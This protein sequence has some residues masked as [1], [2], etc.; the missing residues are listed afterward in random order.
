MNSKGPPSR[1]RSERVSA[2]K[3]DAF[4]RNSAICVG[5]WE[6]A[7]R[8]ATCCFLVAFYTSPPLPSPPVTS[9]IFSHNLFLLPRPPLL[10]GRVLHPLPSLSTPPSP[11]LPCCL[12]NPPRVA[13]PR[14]FPSGSLCVCVCMRHHITKC[15]TQKQ[16][17]TQGLFPDSRHCFIVSGTPFV[18][19]F[20]FRTTPAQAALCRRLCTGASVRC[21][22]P[23]APNTLPCRLPTLGVAKIVDPC[24]T[25][26]Q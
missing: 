10:G 18:A 23:P 11:A 9:P 13:L 4:V 6:A 16:E 19:P 7:G 22:R 1:A 5:E 26:T 12:S 24:S 21:S 20:Q 25:N 8:P 17:H 14:E 3:Q 2:H 15:N